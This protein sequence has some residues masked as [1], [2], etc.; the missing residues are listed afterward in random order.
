MTVRDV[1]AASGISWGTVY[2]H[3]N[4]GKLRGYQDYDYHWHIKPADFFNWVDSCWASNRILMYEPARAWRF[5]RD[6]GLK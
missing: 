3:L 1:V 2:K 5:V 6:F 4:L